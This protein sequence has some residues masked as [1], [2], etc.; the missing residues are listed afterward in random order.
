MDYKKD[1]EGIKQ[2]IK[3]LL[4]LS[5]SPN[6]NEAMAALEKAQKLMDEYHLSA[7][8]CLYEMHSVKATKRLSKWRAILAQTVAP[9][10]YCVTF[11]NV[12]NGEIVFYGDKFDA[13]MAGEMYKYLAKTIERM[14]KLNV[15]KN[16]SLKYRDNYRL[17]IAYRINNRIEEMGQDASWIAERDVRLLTVKKTLEK[18][19]TLSTENMKIGVKNNAFQQGMKAGNGVSLQRQTTGSG[20]RYIEGGHS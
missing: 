7:G 2:K 9:L 18:E 14:S 12:G 4:A 3:K 11:R 13:F 1:V 10:Y 16:A 5:K 19:I 17:G 15:R 8:E 20:G 6:E